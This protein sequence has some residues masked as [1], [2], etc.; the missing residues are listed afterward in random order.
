MKINDR[1]A[2]PVRFE[3]EDQSFFAV[4]CSNRGEPYREGVEIEVGYQSGDSYRAFLTSR[5]L[6]RLRDYL[7][8]ITG[9][10]AVPSSGS[11]A[12]LPAKAQ[13]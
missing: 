3:G 8:A 5:E 9:V 7:N 11:C 10:T 6:M 4:R 1:A 13:E 12:A 2:K